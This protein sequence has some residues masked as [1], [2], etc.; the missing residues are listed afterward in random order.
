[1]NADLPK[2]QFELVNFS[3]EEC[4]FRCFRLGSVPEPDEDYESKLTDAEKKFLQDHV[5]VTQEQ[6]DNISKDPQGGD[7]WKGHRAVRVTPSRFDAAAGLS[8]YQ[9]REECCEEFINPSFDGNK[10]TEYGNA[11][12]PIAR[13]D[14]LIAE[15]KLI[16]DLLNTALKDHQDS[17]IYL[18]RKLPIP[19][20][21]YSQY[22]KTDILEIVVRGL[23]VDVE[24]PWMGGSSDGLLLCTH[25]Q[26]ML[27]G[28]GELIVFGIYRFCLVEFKCPFKKQLYPL[29]P[30]YY[31]AQL[32]GNL[33]I[34]KAEV[35]IFV[36]WCATGFSRAVIEFD[37]VFWEGFLRP[38][39]R[40]FYFKLLLPRLVNPTRTDIEKA[41]ERAN[42]KKRKMVESEEKPKKK[43]AKN[44]ST[45]KPRKTVTAKRTKKG[46]DEK[47]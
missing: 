34:H 38:R 27:G 30:T 35:G 36:V 5:Y 25:L 12:E 16:Q 43:K 4:G 11:S 37:K 9:T 7:R 47:E 23:V 15:R 20:K 6:A 21:F 40:Y 13:E 24:N 26:L 28:L 18:N 44:E 10:A 29:K 17:I 46:K 14:F 8:P 19:P 2:S 1:M 39:L 41:A 42:K 3:L 45:K 22:T 32:Q 31:F 33:H